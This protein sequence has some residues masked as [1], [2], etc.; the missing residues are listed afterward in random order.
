MISFS[1]QEHVEII[2]ARIGVIDIT[3][4][5]VTID[6]LTFYYNQQ[7]DL[8]NGTNNLTI[9]AQDLDGNN[10]SSTATYYF[11]VNV[12][13]NTD[14]KREE[15]IPWLFIIIGIIISV[16]LVLIVGLFKIGYLYFEKSSR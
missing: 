9:I 8:L 13:T 2:S 12:K 7:Y 10:V 15:G 6:N 3:D 14:V 16:I 4:H 1:Y 5:I 11:Q